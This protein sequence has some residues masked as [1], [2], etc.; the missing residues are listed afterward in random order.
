M[1]DCALGHGLALMRPQPLRPHHQGHAVQGHRHQEDG[2]EHAIQPGQHDRQHEDDL[3]RE[4]QD[5][6]HAVEQQFART[7]EPVVENAADLPGAPG[8]VKAQGERVQVLQ[9]LTRKPPPGALLDRA[10]ERPAQLIEQLGQPLDDDIAEQD[11]RRRRQCCRAWV[12]RIDGPGEQQRR[13]RVDQRR[14]G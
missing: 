5:Q 7:V 8:E 3:G 14:G 6:E 11:R 10:V 13:Q 1:S 2:G 12:Q 9:R 4:R